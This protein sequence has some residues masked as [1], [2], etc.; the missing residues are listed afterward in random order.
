MARVRVLT[1]KFPRVTKIGQSTASMR[2]TP[3]VSG[4]GPVTVYIARFKCRA[5]LDPDRAYLFQLGSAHQ[6]VA[7][8]RARSTRLHCH[9]FAEPCST[10]VEPSRFWQC[11]RG[12]SLCKI[13][14]QGELWKSTQHPRWLKHCDVLL[15]WYLWYNFIILI[16]YP[17]TKLRL[18][19]LFI[20]RQYFN[21]HDIS[22]L[23]CAEMNFY[24]HTKFCYIQSWDKEMY[25]MQNIS[26]KKMKTI[27]I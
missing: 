25:Q 21:T 4:L 16:R 9:L 11:K 7:P 24:N 14:N 2:T 15:T 19:L 10:R 5:G 22:P 8:G 17:T 26:V 1:M 27:R 6:K 12:Y 13:A 20:W 23:N 18:S 3:Q